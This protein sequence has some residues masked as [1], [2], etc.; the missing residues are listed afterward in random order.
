LKG[1]QKMSCTKNYLDLGMA[2]NEKTLPKPL[3]E[4]SEK[5]WYAYAYKF[6]TGD[7]LPKN[8]K[9]DKELIKVY[10]P[11]NIIDEAMSFMYGI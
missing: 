1:G 11:A 6:V 10:L 9:R 2:I 4:Y 3:T 7:K 5:E 8:W